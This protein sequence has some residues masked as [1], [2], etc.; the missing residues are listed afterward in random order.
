MFCTEPRMWIWLR[1]LSAFCLFVLTF[2]HDLRLGKNNTC[3]ARV[4][5]GELDLAALTGNTTWVE[6]AGVGWRSSLLPASCC[7]DGV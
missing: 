4:L 5:N 1:L 6:L 3:P 2:A 7:Q